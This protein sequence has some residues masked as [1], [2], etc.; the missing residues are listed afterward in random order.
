MNYEQFFGLTDK[1]FRQSP[2]TD[3]FFSSDGHKELMHHLL[4]CIGSDDGF[5]EITG[6]PGI[7][8]TITVRSLLKQIV[9]DKVRV[10]LI[11]N[12][13]ITPQDLL[14]SFA[15][16]CGMDET[17]IE[18]SP[19]EK[20]LRLLHKHLKELDTNNIVPL[21]IID[22][23]QNLSDDALEQLCLIS[24]LETDKKKLV[25]I[26]LLGQPQLRNRLQD[27]ALKKIDNRITI[28]YHLR[29]LSKA[30]MA[31]YINHRLRIASAPGTPFS[32]IFTEKV[33]SLI[34]KHS[35][36]IPRFVNIICERTLMAA[37]TE[38]ARG[39]SNSHVKK[40]IR[41]FQDEQDVNR[42][43]MKRILWTSASF[44]CLGVLLYI[45]FHLFHS[46]DTKITMH[47]HIQTKVIKP[48][49]IP[50]PLAVTNDTK[51]LIK[52]QPKI[53][54][55]SRITIQP[56]SEL[57]ETTEKT[58]GHVPHDA[59]EKL[60][61]W[62]AQSL[63]TKNSYFIVISPDINRMVVWQG[64]PDFNDLTQV[65]A[66]VLQL[67]EGVYFMDKN[68]SISQ[69][70]TSTTESPLTTNNTIL[71]ENVSF[72]TT[73]LS[74]TQTTK[75][76]ATKLETAKSELIQIT[77]NNQFP[78]NMTESDVTANTPSVQ[79]IKK[80]SKPP[81]KQ[82]INPPKKPAP[83]SEKNSKGSKYLKIMRRPTL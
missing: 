73:V 82:N 55:E 6:E 31:N 46:P 1:P 70:Y 61:T 67:K 32:S 43:S 56:G 62:P 83:A 21:I 60:K 24:N 44:L 9:G 34:Y 59:P 68:Q 5:V 22:E 41:S 2:D 38:N 57:Q 3:Y 33:L 39:L 72:P 75:I 19:G 29:P 36:G 51:D 30:D 12:P 7:G 20:L 17:I 69:I 10:S 77:P 11:V 63:F 27:P 64:K 4:Y 58:W 80:Q 50:Q 79:V 37:F 42:I 71:S 16:D 65:N 76:D 45:I 53:E 28:R 18:Q 78:D 13:K 48:E 15:L 40:A 52:P 14:F 49:T 81:V 25:K 47:K 66:P 23:A 8:K 74:N 26:V 54:T 35:Q